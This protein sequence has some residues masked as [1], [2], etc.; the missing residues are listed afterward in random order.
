MIKRHPIAMGLSVVVHVLLLVVLVVGL[1]RT[2]VPASPQHKQVKTM[3]AVVVDAGAVK[4]EADKLKRAE[5]QK[6]QQEDARKQQLKNEMDQARERR[7]KEEQ[8]IAELQRKQKESEQADK[9]RQQ[10]L[11]Q[12]RKEKQ[13]ELEKLEQQKQAEQKRLTEIAE[14]RKAEEAAEKKRK[15]A[16]EAEARRKQE[17]ADMQRKMAEE[18]QKRAANNSRLQNLRDQY[19]LQIQQHI[20]RNW[21]QPAQ[22]SADWQCEVKV[23]QNAMGDILSVQMVNCSGSEAFRG[24]V[25]QAVIKSSPLPVPR[26]PDVFDKTLRFIF[27]PKS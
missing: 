17:E 13:Q 20:S 24:S 3:E 18:E 16:A 21:L 12:E 22:M 10:K 4:A 7:E 8:R 1:N 11:D 9:L 26:E 27:K 25:E 2:S 15:D 19:L 6:K 14:K 23:Q 5:E